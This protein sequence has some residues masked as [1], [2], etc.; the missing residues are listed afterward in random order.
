MLRGSILGLFLINSQGNEMR[1][2][3][4]A[5]EQYGVTALGAFANILAE[6]PDSPSSNLCGRIWKLPRIT[7]VA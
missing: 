1:G 7:R 2:F 3:I 6:F 5:R 4:F